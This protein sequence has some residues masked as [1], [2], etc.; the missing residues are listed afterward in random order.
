MTRSSIEEDLTFQQYMREASVLKISPL[1]QMIR[2]RQ[3]TSV[4]DKFDYKDDDDLF[5]RVTALEHI[6][7]KH[8]SQ[9]SLIVNKPPMREEGKHLK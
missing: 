7:I 5:H 3:N 8:P 6:T 4:I 9:K 1:M 2:D